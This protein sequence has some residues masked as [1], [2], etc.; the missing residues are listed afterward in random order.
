MKK[1]ALTVCL[2]KAIEE[3]RKTVAPMGGTISSEIELSTCHSS[4][5]LQ[6]C[7]YFRGDALSNFFSRAKAS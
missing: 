3:I 6:F 2:A 5:S 4:Q 1:E 7:I